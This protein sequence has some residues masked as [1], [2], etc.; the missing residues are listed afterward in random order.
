[1][2]GAIER[3][4]EMHRKLGQVTLVDLFDCDMLESDYLF[5]FLGF[6]LNFLTLFLQ[7]LRF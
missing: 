6:Q 4:K 5:V 1:M 2:L 3:T 7:M